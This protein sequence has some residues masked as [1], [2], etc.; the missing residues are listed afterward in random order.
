MAYD[1]IAVLGAGA[2]GSAL[3]NLAAQA[4]RSVTLWARDPARAAAM[5]KSRSSPRLP[6]AQLHER[7]GVTSILAEAAGADAILL[8]VPAQA[9]R[10]IVAQL[11]GLDLTPVIAC[12]K[13]SSA[14]ATNS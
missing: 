9:T 6:G 12:A 3:A 5:A 10:V 14:A 1:H 13:G 11:S 7:V 8:V 2:W 4:G